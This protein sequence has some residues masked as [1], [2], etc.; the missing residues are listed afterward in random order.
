M[1]KLANG[2]LKIKNASEVFGSIL[3]SAPDVDRCIAH[4]GTQGLVLNCFTVSILY[5]GKAHFT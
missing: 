2:E 3:E 4:P 5:N 1:Q